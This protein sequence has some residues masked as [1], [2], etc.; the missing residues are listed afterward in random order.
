[1]AAGAGQARS[2]NLEKSRTLFD[3]TA[4]ILPLV[5]LVVYPFT[6]IAAPA[7]L[8]LSIVKWRHPLSLVRRNRWRFIAAIAISL[9]EIVGWS[10]LIAYLVSGRFTRPN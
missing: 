9:G 10:L 4:L 3:S 7:S 6:V 2:A 1:V 5:S 8:V